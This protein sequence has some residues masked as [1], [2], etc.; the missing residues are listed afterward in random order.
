M[1]DFDKLPKM[2]SWDE[3]DVLVPTS[4]L[5]LQVS[6]PNYNIT[7]SNREGLQIGALDFNGGAMVFE[8]NAEESAIVLFDFVAHYFDQRLKDEYQRGYE[9]AKKENTL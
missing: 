1:E 9:A 3:K 8:G 5:T 6:K 7:F 2:Q 4:Q